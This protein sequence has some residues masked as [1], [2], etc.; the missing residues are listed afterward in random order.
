V[1]PN[2]KER[3]CKWSELTRD[4]K[5]ELCECIDSSGSVE[6]PKNQFV[7]ES[8]KIQDWEVAGSPGEKGRV[9]VKSGIIEDT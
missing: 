7:L 6:D 8:L 3:N 2:A 5:G 4:I 1:L 9:V